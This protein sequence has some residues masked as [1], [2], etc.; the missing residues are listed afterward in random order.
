MT[1]YVMRTLGIER[2]E[3]DALRDALLADLRHDA[4][5]ADARARRRSRALPRRGAR[6]RPLG[7]ARRRRSSRAAIGRL[8]GRKVV[9]TNGSREHARRVTRRGAGSTA[10]STRSTA[11][12]TRATCRSPRRRPSPRS[13]RS[14]G[15]VPARAAMFED[16]HRN[17]AVPHGLGMRTVLVGPAAD[18]SARPPP[19]RGPRRVPRAAGLTRTDG[20]DRDRRAG[21]GRRRRRAAAAAAFAAAGFRVLCVDPVPPVTSAEAEGSDL[22]STAFLMPAVGAARARRA[23]GAAGAACRGAADHAHRRRRRRRRRRSARRADFEARELGQDAFGYNLPNWL[24]RREMVARL[25]EL[26]GAELRAGASV[27]RVT[28]RTDAALA[29]LSDGAQVRAALVVAADGRD[30]AVREALGIGVRRWG[31]GQKALVF[32]VT[33]PVPHAGVSIE[34]HRS[35][36]P[37]TLVPLRD[38]DGAP[39]SAVVW[40]ETGPRAADARRDA[41]GRVRGGAERPRRRRVR[42]AP[43]REP[44]AALADR[45]AGGGAARRPAR[46]AGGR[47]RA[48]GAADRGAGAQHEPARHRDAAR[49]L[50]GG[51]RRRPATSARRIC[52]RATSGRATATCCCGSPGSTR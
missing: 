43:P 2:R 40:M 8:P 18:A 9:F 24:L 22:R 11:S 5:R 50:R 21:G 31:Y 38:R 25:A 12:R 13:S 46:G 45:G 27:E 35:G 41:G 49:S 1:A 16:D 33:H 20:A 14:T 39:A 23:L 4:G 36:G 3:A 44:A 15:C 37:F 7:G 51:A 30:S 47:G 17:L 48:R 26:P 42:R 19:D 52:S 6:H 34:I 10:A 29:A 28:P 32:T